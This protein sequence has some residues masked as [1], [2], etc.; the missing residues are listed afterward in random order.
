MSKNCFWLYVNKKFRIEN[1]LIK[2][3]LFA[4]IIKK[5]GIV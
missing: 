3:M 4:K 5:E 2:K 1:V